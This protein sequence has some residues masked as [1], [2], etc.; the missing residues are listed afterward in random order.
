MTFKKYYT[1]Y[2]LILILISVLSSCFNQDDCKKLELSSEEMQ[3][4]KN[5]TSGDTVFFKNQDNEMDTF[6]IHADAS[7]DYTSCNK[8]ELGPYVYALN[9]LSFNN[10]DDYE[11]S[12]TRKRYSL[13]FDK[14]GQDTFDLECHKDLGFFDLNV[15]EFIDFKEI[16]IEVFTQPKTNEKIELLVYTKNLNCR[17]TEGGIE[18]MQAFFI[19]KKYGLIRYKTINGSTYERVW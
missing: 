14:I 13:G 17:N 11:I 1:F 3:W 5:Y 7:S 8:F 6:V 19:S 10:I 2:F 12:K 16:P 15:D 18:I 9:S 4:F